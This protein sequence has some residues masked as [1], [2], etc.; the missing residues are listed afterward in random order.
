LRLRWVEVERITV[1][2]FEVND[3]SG[4][5]GSCGGI[6]V[7]TDTTKLPNMVIAGFGDS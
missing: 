6:E 4:N 1:I 3:G 7:R 5:R 2:E